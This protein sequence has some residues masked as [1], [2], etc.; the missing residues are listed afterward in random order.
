MPSTTQRRPVAGPIARRN[1]VGTSEQLSGR[2]R[3]DLELIARYQREGDES[4]RDELVE[5]T[6][7]IARRL[8]RRYQRGSEPLED[9][10]QVASVG[11]VKAVDRFDLERGLPFTRYATPTILGE[12]KRHFRDTG[13]A[14]HLPREMQERVLK[15]Q[16]SLA[17]LG[18]RLGRSPTAAEIADDL[19]LEVEQ[20]LEAF[21]AAGAYS[22]VSLD[23]PRPGDEGDRES[24]VDTIGEEDDRYEL[25]EDAAAALPALRALPAR[26]RL[27]LRLRFR[28]GLTQ[29]QIG[30]QVGISQM[31]VSRLLRRALARVRTIALN[32]RPH[33]ADASGDRRLR[34]GSG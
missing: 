33:R 21:E 19:G 17:E 7:P 11:L 15:L 27:I 23:A 5:R 2:A 4:A 22:A 6:L 3:D 10:V 24:Y 25:V 32:Q 30:E 31:H 20:V 12:L 13:W 18:S 14:A 16:R 29:Q 34:A 1:R 26:E 9:L 28:D 8:A